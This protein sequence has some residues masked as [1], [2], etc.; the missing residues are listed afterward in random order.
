MS[1][2]LEMQLEMQLVEV[3][4]KMQSMIAHWRKEWKEGVTKWSEQIKIKSLT[5]DTASVVLPYNT[6]IEYCLV[7]FRRN[8]SKDPKDLEMLYDYHSYD[9]KSAIYYVARSGK[10][11][12]LVPKNLSVDIFRHFATSFGGK[13][14]DAV[15]YNSSCSCQYLWVGDENKRHYKIIHSLLLSRGSSNSV[16]DIA[17]GWELVDIGVIQSGGKLQAS[18][19]FAS[20]LWE[21]RRHQTAKMIDFHFRSHFKR[22]RVTAVA[23]KFFEQLGS[24][25][26]AVYIANV[27]CFDLINPICNDKSVRDTM[28][29][30]DLEDE[31][32]ERH[33]WVSLMKNTRFTETLSDEAQS[34]SLTAADV[35]FLICCF[36]DAKYDREESMEKIESGTKFPT[37]SDNFYNFDPPHLTGLLAKT[38]LS[39]KLAEYSAGQDEISTGAFALLAPLA[40]TNIVAD[41]FPVDLLAQ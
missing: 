38:F 1:T 25:R 13:F 7:S 15:E 26:G 20:L 36:I 18:Y 19:Y 10:N 41:Y 28:K 6:T 22:E 4:I 35:R 11:L 40:L 9:A 34:I 32:S 31:N 29:N 33:N 12:D 3:K 23:K 21:L 27:F 17:D 39:R 30:F 2:Q 14:S 8:N 5:K 24:D 37:H 16:P